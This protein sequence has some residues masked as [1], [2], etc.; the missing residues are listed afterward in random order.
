M[1]VKSKIKI[2]FLKLMF[3]RPDKGSERLKTA[4]YRPNT[5]RMNSSGFIPPITACKEEGESSNTARPITAVRPVG[6]S[7][8]GAA[9]G[10]LVG[11]KPIILL[12]QLSLDS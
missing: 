9:K 1:I 4:G 12:S 8:K 5:G 6:F 10:H 7:S 2:V 3:L 11:E